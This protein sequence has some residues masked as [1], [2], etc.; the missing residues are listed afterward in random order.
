MDRSVDR[1][2]PLGPNS[3]SSSAPHS[4]VRWHERVLG[5]WRVAQDDWLV[6][7]SIPPLLSLVPLM[8]MR[9]ITS[10]VVSPWIAHASNDGGWFGSSNSW[11]VFGKLIKKRLCPLDLSHLHLKQ[12]RSCVHVAHTIQITV[13]EDSCYPPELLLGG[14]LIPPCL[15]IYSL[16]GTSFL[17][18]LPSSLPFLSFSILKHLPQFFLIL[19]YLHCGYTAILLSLHPYFLV[20]NPG[21]YWGSAM[22]SLDS[23]LLLPLYPLVSTRFNRL[24][25]W[26]LFLESCSQ[27]GLRD[28]WLL[29]W[30]YICPR[31]HEYPVWLFKVRHGSGR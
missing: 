22:V 12:S 7:S 20:S 2:R 29:G 28:P 16:V 25:V 4:L 21:F 6:S 13:L 27:R 31:L 17:F 8:A 30:Q 11:W 9:C 23:L 3:T 24:G 19:L 14:I 26:L 1:L 10:T 18:L 15:I 5:I